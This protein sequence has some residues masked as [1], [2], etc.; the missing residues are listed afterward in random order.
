MSVDAIEEVANAVLYEGYLLYPYRPSAVKNRQRWNFGVVY[1]PRYASAQSGEDASQMQVECLARGT[2]L[3]VRIRFLRL[4]AREGAGADPSGWQEAEERE[5]R[6]NARSLPELA[7]KPQWRIFAIH[8]STA[9]A[10]GVT[11]RRE[12][13]QGQVEAGATAIGGQWY[14]LRVRVQ[15]TSPLGPGPREDALLQ[16]FVS[17]HAILTLDGGEFASLLEPQAEVAEQAE[18]CRN[19]GVFPVLAGEPGS[20]NAMLCSP[21]I[22]YDYPQIA[23]ESAGALFDG[24]EID[25]ILSLRILT[26]TDTEKAEM[27][28]ADPL[29]REILER[30]EGLTGEQLMKMHGKLRNLSQEGGGW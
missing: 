25:E 22:L 4:L 7:R 5:I 9:E 29:A 27:R 12:A 8:P 18:R 16:S 2:G 20:R 13:L 21:V 6:F 28:A 15:N 24:T 3:G 26:M 1:P 23:P 14:R 10:G 19:V 11:R 30:T 17:T